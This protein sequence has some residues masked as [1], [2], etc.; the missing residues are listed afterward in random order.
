MYW[1]RLLIA[2]GYLFRVIDSIF[3][4]C[5]SNLHLAVNIDK[6][7]MKFNEWNF[8]QL[9]EL[10]LILQLVL[11]NLKTNFSYFPPIVLF[12]RAYAFNGSPRTS[13]VINNAIQEVLIIIMM[14]DNCLRCR[15]LQKTKTYFIAPH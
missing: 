9:E 12:L 4:E 2:L 11:N 10:N 13:S 3:D 5:C 7:T 1:T 8:R 14:I 6:R 15:A